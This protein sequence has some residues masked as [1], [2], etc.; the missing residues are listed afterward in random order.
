MKSALPTPSPLLVACLCAQWCKLC[1]DYRAVFDA[2]AQAGS[3]PHARFVWIDI[4]DDETVL[5]PVDVDD[6]PTLLIVSGDTPLFFGP[7]TPHPGTLAR[8][9]KS[10]AADELG[11]LTDSATRAL[12]V[13]VADHATAHDDRAG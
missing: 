10:A 9:L 3:R 8:L 2:A 13:R 1:D 7:L 12:A 4:E 11:Q 5:G 6:F